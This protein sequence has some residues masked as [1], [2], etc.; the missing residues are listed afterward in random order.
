MQLRKLRAERGKTGALTDHGSKRFYGRGATDKDIENAIASAI[1]A[2]KT[3]T[4]KGGSYNQLQTHYR[5]SNGLTV[6][7]AE[8]GR[9]TGQII[10][11][12]GKK[13]GGKF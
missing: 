8:E 10:T 2:N 7:I 11:I 12:F 9:K 4:K 13:P 6:I 5:G 3:I 1:R